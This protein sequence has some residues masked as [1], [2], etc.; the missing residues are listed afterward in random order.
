MENDDY[1][2]GRSSNSD[3]EYKQPK[4]PTQILGNHRKVHSIDTTL[5]ETNYNP[6]ALPEELKTV[7]G[8]SVRIF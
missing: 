4:R 5:D 6:I 1:E 8:I 2:D 3:D 7:Q